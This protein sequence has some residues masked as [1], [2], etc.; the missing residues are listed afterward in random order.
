MANTL[1]GKDFVA[2]RRLSD[3][4]GTTIAA[5]GQTCEGVPAGRLGGTVSDAL[6]KLLASGKIAPVADAADAVMGESSIDRVT[7]GPDVEI[8]PVPELK[9]RRRSAAARESEA[10]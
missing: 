8:A 2:L 3:Q 9:T 1:H 7:P 10:E 5:V 6:R 4:A